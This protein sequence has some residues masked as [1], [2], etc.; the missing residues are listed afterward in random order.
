MKTRTGQR[1]ITLVE[2]IVVTGITAIIVAI[3]GSAV[4]QILQVT[5]QG[6]NEFRALHDI[7]NAGYWITLD[8]KRAQTT[9][10]T[11]NA[12]PVGSMSL[13]WTE[14]GQSHT[15]TYSL[16]GASLQRNYDGTVTTVARYISSVGF[17]LSQDSIITTTVTSSPDGRWEV[18]ETTTYKTCMRPIS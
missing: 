5:G 9:S 12:A 3:L 13:N 14:G 6:N 4:F 11:R 17:S 18:S 10:L 2:A 8:G 1:G 16:S 7:Q 15:V